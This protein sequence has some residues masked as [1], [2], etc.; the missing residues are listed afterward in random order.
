MIDVGVGG[1]GS[2]QSGEF[3]SPAASLTSGHRSTPL[4]PFLLMKTLGYV[5]VDL[6]DLLTITKDTLKDI[7]S[8][9][10]RILINLRNANLKVNADK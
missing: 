4:D 10:R 8:K 3:L 7:L 5:Q 6:D 1:S 2:T 9:Q